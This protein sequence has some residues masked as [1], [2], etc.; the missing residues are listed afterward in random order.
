MYFF[1]KSIKL[2]IVSFCFACFSLVL[3]HPGYLLW[4]NNKV[5]V[6]NKEKLQ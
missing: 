5:E 3:P 1:K 2:Q 4:E 6:K